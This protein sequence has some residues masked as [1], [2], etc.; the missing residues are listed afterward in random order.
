MNARFQLKLLIKNRFHF[1]FVLAS[2]VTYYYYY[3]Y[4]SFVIPTT[5]R[6]MIRKKI[7]IIGAGITGATTASFLKAA[8][9]KLNVDVTILDKGRGAGGRMTTS[10]SD[11]DNRMHLDLGAQYI[12]VGAGGGN[13]SPI[14]SAVSYETLLSNELIVPFQDMVQGARETHNEQT[15][16]IAPNGLSSVV[17][18][19]LKDYKDNTHYKCKVSSISKFKTEDNG[20][21]QWKV[22]H[23]CNNEKNINNIFDAIVLTIPTHQILELNGDFRD[24]LASSLNSNEDNLLTRLQKVSY[25][26]RWALGLYY[27]TE[28]WKA[29]EAVPWVGKYTQKEDDAIVWVS[30]ESKKRGAAN[31][32][33]NDQKNNVGPV[34]VVHGAVP[35]SLQHF[36]DSRDSIMEEMKSRMEKFVP[37]IE[38]HNPIDSKLIRWKYSQVRPETTVGTSKDEAA[39]LVHKDNDDNP[40][41][42]LAGDGISGSNFE[43]CIRSG[44]IASHLVQSILDIDDDGASKM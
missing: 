5:E 6:E 21:Y 2:I 7:L 3:L 10:R 14:N 22:N 29:I 41:L 25:S 15:H 24:V 20:H 38:K 35:W 34:I 37:G 13:D 44:M 33:E 16:Y 17:N 12:T 19:L 4:H 23:D 9:N 36:E 39:I 30:L 40:P 43:N 32:I 42:I 1:V 8:S 27:P 18:N 26:S 28:A 11:L 31:Y